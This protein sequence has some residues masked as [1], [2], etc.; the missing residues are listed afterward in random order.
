MGKVP[1]NGSLPRGSELIAYSSLRMLQHNTALAQ[2][3][4]MIEEYGFD[5]IPY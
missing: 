1:D 3:T 4:E 5:T 2:I